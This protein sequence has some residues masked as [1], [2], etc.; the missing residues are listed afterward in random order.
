MISRHPR[1]PIEYAI[2]QHTRPLTPEEER[3][4]DLAWYREQLDRAEMSGPCAR[5]AGQGC[6]ACYDTGQVPMTYDQARARD[7]REIA[8]AISS[9]V[10][11]YRSTWD[12]DDGVLPHVLSMAWR[13]AVMIAAIADGIERDRE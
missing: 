13:C 3:A 5:C 2:E 9:S 8:T 7:L 6:D 4:R 11:R 1:D 10:E 12:E